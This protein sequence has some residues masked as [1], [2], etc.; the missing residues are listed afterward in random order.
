MS[1]PGLDPQP[2]VHPFD[3]PAADVQAQ[4]HAT[5]RTSQVALDL[6]EAIEDSLLLGERDAGT[7]VPHGDGGPVFFDGHAD[8]DGLVWR[9]VLQRVGEEVADHEPDA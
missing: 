5:P 8:L 2:A 4:A 3:E 9:R 1:G 6:V 7:F